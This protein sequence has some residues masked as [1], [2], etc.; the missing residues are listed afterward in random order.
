[1]IGGDAGYGKS[2][3]L[4]AFHAETRELGVVAVQ[5]GCVEIE[6]QRPFGAFADLISSCER[7]FGS[8][9]VARAL[10]EHGVLLR[11]LRSPA[12][13]SG[14]GGHR[15]QMHSAILSLLSD[16]TADG[17]LAVF[18]EDLHWADAASVELFG[19]LT[20]RL[21]SR[22][23]LLI[24]T[25]RADEL[26]RRHPLRAAL[27]ELRRARLVQDIALLPLD[28]DGTEALIRARL[29]VR[30]LAS[31]DLRE[32]RDLLH[33]RCEGNPLHTE[34]TLET[35]KQSGRLTFADG[36]WACD[37]AVVRD[38]MPASVAD[39]VIAR[40]S[41]LTRPAQQLLLV[42]SV[43]GQ[44][45]DFDLLANVSDTTR[46]AMAPLIH[47]AID[48]RLLREETSDE[49]LRFHH[50]L[51]RE[52]LRRQLLQSERAGLHGRIAAYLAQMRGSVSIPAAELA[53][54]LEESGDAQRARPFHELAAREAAAITDY[55][56]AARSMERAIATAPAGDSDQGGRYL[57][58]VGYLRLSGDDPRARRAAEAALKIGERTG[59]RRLQAAACLEIFAGDYRNSDEAPSTKE[60]DRAVAL[61]E[62]LGPTPE[63]ARALAQTAG[64]AARAVDGVR[65]VAFAERALLTATALQLPAERAAAKL[66]ISIGLHTQGKLSEA[67]SV[68][69]EA[70]EIGEQAGL[71]QEL[72]GALLTL[73]VQ[74]VAHG[75]SVEDQRDA[76]LRMR[77]VGRAHGL[78]RQ[79]WIGRELLG[80]FVEGDWDAFLKLIPQAPEPDRSDFDVP[81]LVMNFVEVARHG[82]RDAAAQ[83]D[84]LRLA[85]SHG[86]SG[87][88]GSWSA[89]VLLLAGRLL[90]SVRTAQAVRDEEIRGK[91]WGLVPAA[92]AHAFGLVAARITG[93]E[94]ARDI[95]LASLLKERPLPVPPTA[96]RKYAALAEGDIAERGGARDEALAAYAQTV[97]ECERSQFTSPTM[98]YL[99]TLTRLRRAELY[100][101]ADQPDRTS[102]QAELDSLLPYWRK[103][104]ATWYLGQLRV[105]AE[106]HGLA[107]P[108][109]DEP[110]TDAPSSPKQLTRRELE[111]ARLVARGLT[112]RE[113]STRLTL[114]V[115]TAESHV[116]QIR[117][118]L[119]F[120]TRAQI[121]AWI[122]ERYGPASAD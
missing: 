29:R 4:A 108:R 19:Y 115:R 114:S 47:E 61:L 45:F 40:W 17:P 33:A 20:R 88:V 18:L 78:G 44:R 34:E 49:P 6:A 100:L 39:G 76:Q 62:P 2:A 28:A 121:A 74:L 30:D 21:R 79:D 73:R 46:E 26:D 24:A 81:R 56:S 51:T 27:A 91:F 58:L 93:D 109:T 71:V 31:G 43:I 92:E 36:A 89:A 11:Q 42:A 15:Y 1:M 94:V 68:C 55:R 75:A 82:P 38:A 53:Y 59:E 77:A 7:A 52:A 95:F 111:I 66:Q 5:G 23:A 25:Y 41:A 101:R 102:A 112:N 13:A 54:H 97:A 120:R 110:A 85:K 122:T 103:A 3:L 118:K 16:L 22:P 99:G 119:G 9:R 12:D 106:E 86:P 105:W 83:D 63:L 10:Q 50:A 64:A 57:A 84:A 35:L 65:A 80:L 116:E 72:Y 107:F 90:E 60:L 37:A 98:L 67:L 70:I 8:G 96:N 32:L 69:R 113:I 104:K 87:P 117:T 14:R 48:A